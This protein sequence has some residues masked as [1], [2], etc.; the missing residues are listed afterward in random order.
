[1]ARVV[2]VQEQLDYPT[3]HL[4]GPEIL[5][6]FLESF[7]LAL[8]NWQLLGT[9]SAVTLISENRAKVSANR[10]THFLPVKIQKARAYSGWLL[11]DARRIYTDRREWQSA[12]SKSI[13]K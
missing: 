4:V 3:K 6:T 2:A 7:S 11:N 8:R 10:E 13:N 9:E 1:M 5:P 12:R